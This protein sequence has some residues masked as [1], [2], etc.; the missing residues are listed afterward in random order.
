VINAA[1]KRGVLVKDVREVHFMLVE[2]GNNR[3]P[4]YKVER[5]VGAPGTT[6][7]PE[8]ST[9]APDTTIAAPP[10][11]AEPRTSTTS[12]RGAQPRRC[13]VN[14]SR[15]K[16]S[17]LL[18][19]PGG[20]SVYVN[21]QQRKEKHICRSHKASVVKAM[22]KEGIAPE[23]VTKIFF[24]R[25]A[26]SMKKKIYYTVEKIVG[27]DERPPAQSSTDPQLSSLAPHTQSTSLSPT[28]PSTRQ[29]LESPSV[30]SPPAGSSL[31]SIV[32]YT[33]RFLLSILRR[34]TPRRQTPP[35]SATSSRQQASS[36]SSSGIRKEYKVTESRRLRRNRGTI[37][38][39]EAEP[40]K[41]SS[42]KETGGGESL[43][44]DDGEGSGDPSG[45]EV[46]SDHGDDPYQQDLSMGDNNCD[47]SSSDLFPDIHNVSSDSESGDE[48]PIG[49][50]HPDKS[51][52][53][54]D[55]G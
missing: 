38:H 12:G 10:N 7:T 32:K 40:A 54:P 50:I 37:R 33:T 42:E 39:T 51:P 9:A 46:D 23:K 41:P 30:V 14:A 20:W 47:N 43:S 6:T 49:S 19:L 13:V 36:L 44:E 27:A 17:G 28:L 11:S 1:K 15:C 8:T 35:M 31:T 45:L 3:K 4:C 55:D 48:S 5:I 16:S 34:K 24:K 29:Q 26:T 53:N 25:V 21:G 22:K 52:S 2:V 18:N